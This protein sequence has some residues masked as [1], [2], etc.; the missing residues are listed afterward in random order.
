MP[1]AELPVQD[2]L[3]AAVAERE[4]AGRIDQAIALLDQRIG[5]ARAQLSGLLAQ[6]GH[7]AGRALRAREAMRSLAE[8][9]A[10]DPHNAGVEMELALMAR[11]QGEL[12][13]SLSH[14][15]HLEQTQ[16]HM[17]QCR[18]EAGALQAR[19]GQLDRALATFARMPAAVTDGYWLAEIDHVR[20][21]ARAARGTAL[22]LLGRRRDGLE[23]AG[24]RDLA[25]A[26]L[27][28]GREHAALGIIAT[29]PPGLEASRLRFEA[30]HRRLGLAG[31]AA[32]LRAGAG[33]GALPAELAALV[34]DA[35]Y[36]AGRPADALALLGAIPFEAMSS[37]VQELLFRAHA[38]QGDVPACL[39]LG[40]RMIDARPWDP[41]PAQLVIGALL[42]GGALRPVH[43]ALGG[44]PPG[45]GRI[46]PV[47]FQFWD[48]PAVPAEVGAVIA[49]WD[50]P[51]G[52]LQRVLFDDAQA[53]A[54]IAMEFPP[55]HLAA[56]RACHH[57]AMRSDLVRL[58][59]LVRHGGIYLDVDEHCA[60]TPAALLRAV[61]GQ[62]LL[63]VLIGS[64]AAYANNALIGAEPGHPLLQHALADAVRVLT[65][66]HEGARPDIWNTT[67]PGLIT[68][69]LVAHLREYGTEGSGRVALLTDAAWRQLCG[70]RNSLAYKGTAAG[71]WRLA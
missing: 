37:S 32:V 55:D 25:R 38:A 70:A 28:L 26:L 57:A 61:S 15:L 14:W 29:L 7:L 46:P 11:E 71:N 51:S 43:D 18:F 9:L 35:Y 10:L 1:L 5:E 17:L 2:A 44:L 31:A 16:P 20:Q 13:R 68:R 56:Y 53:Q 4:A 42:A 52:H 69:S 39:A 66:L 59:Y 24:W 62:S 41:T 27:R 3:L 60:D 48:Q 49:S 65:S 45:F 30:D 54:F 58:C 6:R 8:A 19:A 23:E 21:L 63:L 36:Q 12:E 47:L 40:G 67:G 64:A 33:E 22:A 34:A 50:D